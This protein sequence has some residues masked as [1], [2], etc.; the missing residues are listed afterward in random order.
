MTEEERRNFLT[1][2]DFLVIDLRGASG[3]DL[4]R[5][6]G[7][8]IG[9]VEAN[10]EAAAALATL[11]AQADMPAWFTKLESSVGP[12]EGAGTF[13]FVDLPWSYDPTVYL[14]ER[15]GR[16]QDLTPGGIPVGDG[17]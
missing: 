8:W 2:Y 3:S 14:A 7:R 13:G 5:I 12:L 6:L 4:P 16:G 1:G 9:H 17:A 11:E 15:L 10:P